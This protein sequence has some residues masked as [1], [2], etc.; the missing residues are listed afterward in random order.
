MTVGGSPCA[1]RRPSIAITEASVIST[2]PMSAVAG[3]ILDGLLGGTT[4]Y[5]ARAVVGAPIDLAGLDSVRCQACS[6]VFDGDRTGQAL[7]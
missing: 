4:G 2:V 1:I 6:H 3:A 5:A 7:T